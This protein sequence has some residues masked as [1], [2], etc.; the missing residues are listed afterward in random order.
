MK[1]ILIIDDDL[2]FRA[3]LRK[4]FEGEGFLTAEAASGLIA[5]RMF[6]NDQPDAVILDQ[7]TR[8]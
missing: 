5:M 1:K 2:E 8:C 6:L 3:V 4:I 7:A